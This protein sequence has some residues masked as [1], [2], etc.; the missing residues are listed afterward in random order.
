M[1][2]LGIHLLVADATFSRLPNST[3]NDVKSL[4]P[5]AKYFPEMASLGAIG[6]DLLYYLGD[7]PKISAVVADVFHY[8]NQISSVLK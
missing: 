4:A 6:P 3:V 5:I 8:L 1:P 7:G 2:S